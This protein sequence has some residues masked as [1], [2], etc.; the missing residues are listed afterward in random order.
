MKI[1][2]LEIKDDNTILFN[3]KT[4]RAESEPVMSDMERNI[5][6]NQPDTVEQ[7]EPK[8]KSEWDILKLSQD[9]TVVYALSADGKYYY[10]VKTT[11]WTVFNKQL[12]LSIAMP[13]INLYHRDNMEF[14]RETPDKHYDLAIV[15]FK[16]N[17][18][19]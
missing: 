12:I 13:N 9:G 14:M 6:D 15:D 5:A 7:A 4:Y 11:E 3:G 10:D 17:T 19:I 16:I 18:Y 1:E 8:W 2:N